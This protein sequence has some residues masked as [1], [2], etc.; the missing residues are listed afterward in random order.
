MRCLSCG[1]FVDAR[2]TNEAL[3]VGRV[4][5]A[6]LF[7]RLEVLEA[8]PFRF[9]ARFGLEE[10]PRQPGLILVRGARPQPGRALGRDG[11][12][13]PVRRHSRGP[14]QAGPRGRAGQ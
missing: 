10:L 7:P 13:L 14:G 2:Q 6:G 12:S 1:A 8:A 5:A 11:M 4:D 3:A 9:K